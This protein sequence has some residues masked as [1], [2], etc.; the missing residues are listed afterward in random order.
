MQKNILVFV[1]FAFF[2]QV[3]N[4]KN[5][6]SLL[7][8]MKNT[9]QKVS[10]KDS[11]DFYRVILSPDTAIDKDLY[12][13]FDYYPNGQLKAA[14]TSLTKD[15]KPVWDG[16]CIVYFP[17]GKR[18]SILQFKNGVVSGNLV[19][20]Y[21][22][23]QLYTRLK[24]VDEDNG[25]YDGYYTGYINYHRIK[26]EVEEL[27]DSTGNLLVSNGTGHVIAYDEDFNKII[28]EGDIKHNKK[29]GLWKGLIGDTARFTCIYHRDEIKSGTSY[30]KSGQQYNFKKISTDPVFSDGM[31]AFYLYLKKNVQYPESAKKHRV[32]GSVIVG[33]YVETNGTISDV[34]I[35]KGLIKSLDDEALRVIKMSP[36][37]I[38]ATEY[39]IPLRS[40]FKVS[41]AFYDY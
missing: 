35:V 17:S 15:A 28:A 11:A 38:P 5:P 8:Y 16:N 6:D 1:L 25:Y 3:A 34:T 21:P 33:F 41:V 2:M 26:V 20:Y 30:T 4:A 40:Q 14:A 32:M 36:L 18:K 23:G 10:T 12:R 37:W 27:R 19:N 24:A 7:V 31:D 29:D 22:N 13:I 39:G 9:G